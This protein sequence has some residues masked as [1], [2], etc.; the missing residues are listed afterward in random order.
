MNHFSGCGFFKDWVLE[1]WG[2]VGVV[3]VAYR[4]SQASYQ[5]HAIAAVQAQQ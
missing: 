1:G 2:G 3:P 5:T 4:S